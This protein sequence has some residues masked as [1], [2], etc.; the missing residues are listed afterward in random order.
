MDL[1]SI[2]L[3]PYI[4]EMDGACG[5]WI[6]IPLAFFLIYGRWMEPKGPVENGFWIPWAFGCHV[7]DATRIVLDIEGG[8][9]LMEASPQ[10]RPSGEGVR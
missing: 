6:W 3:F 5:K 9:R 7:Q 10:A 1:D 8:L 2:G 4:W